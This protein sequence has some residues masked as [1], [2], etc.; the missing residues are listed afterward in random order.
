MIFIDVSF[1]NNF[2]FISQIKSVICLVDQFN[3]ANI[4]YLLFTKYKSLTRSILT[5]EL[6]IMVYDFNTKLIIKSTIK[7]IIALFISNFIFAL[8]NIFTSI[9]NLSA[10]ILPLLLLF[11]IIC[12]H[13]KFLYNYLI[14]LGNVY[15]KTFIIDIMYFKQSYKQK[16]IIK[17]K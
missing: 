16:E 12:I 10:F 5:L 13:L 7:K 9:F 17:I 3:K 11:I 4:I 14:K 2:N 8:D 15:K 1:A 6:Y